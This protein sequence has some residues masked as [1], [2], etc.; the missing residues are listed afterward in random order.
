MRAVKFTTIILFILGYFIF[1]Q[2]GEYNHLIT[3][4]NVIGAG[5]EGYFFFRD[6]HDNWIYAYYVWLNLII[7]GFAYI[8][9]KCMNTK[10]DRGLFLCI[11]VVQWLRLIFQV[12]EIF[13]A[14]TELI[15]KIAESLS[16]QMV[17]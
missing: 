13:G 9:Y 10:V 15:L 3:K 4:C 7:L 1:T 8:A 17:N 5:N 2:F 12:F 16:V 6:E 11:V 14:K